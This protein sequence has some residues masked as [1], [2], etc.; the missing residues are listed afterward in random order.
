MP[1]LKIFLADLTYNTV[2]LSNEVFP[3]NVGFITSYCK[4]HFNTQVEITIFKYIDKLE[5]AIYEA[6]P[7]ILGISNY[8]WCQNIGLEMFRIFK[9][10]NP[11]GVTV[12]GG[13]NF[14]ADYQSQIA[15][16]KKH[17]IVDVYIPLEGEFGFSKVVER[18][19][20]RK[21]QT[22][23]QAIRSGDIEYCITRLNNGEL[24]YKNVGYRTQNLEEI[25]SP[26]L[27]GLLDEFFDDRLNPMIQTN[28]GCPFSC[29]F[30]VDGNDDV[31]KVNQFSVERVKQELEYIAKRVP[32]STHGLFIGDLNFGMYQR[33]LEICERIADIQQRYEYPK[34]IS[35]TTGKNSKDRI[36]KAIRKL[37]GTLKITM[38]VQSMDEQVLQNIRRDNISV[39]QMTALRPVIQEADLA[40][41]SEVILGLPGDSYDTHTR[42]IRDLIQ[43][44]TDKIL[45]YSLMMLNGS[46]L[47]IPEERQKWGIK[48]KFRILPRDFIRLRNGKTIIEID[49]T[50]V[51]SNTMSFDDYVQLRILAFILWTSYSTQ[52]QAIFKIFRENGIDVFDLFH[53]MLLNLKN[54]PSLI[55]QVIKEVKDATINELWDSPEE[56][57]EYFQDEKNYQKLLHEEMGYNVIQYFY[58][59]VVSYYSNELT[60][61][62]LKEALQMIQKKGLEE[63]IIEQFQDASNYCKGL[64]FNL[65]SKDRMCTNPEFF[66]SYNIKDWLNDNSDLKLKDFRLPEKSKVVFK[67][68]NDQTKMVND[69][70]KSYGESGHAR[71]QILK[72]LGIVL[73]SRKPQLSS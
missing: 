61:Y 24:Q 18:I 14:P 67:L 30:C 49:E 72:H 22:P 60:Q 32:K 41:I 48:T 38:S 70:F 4:S 65:F 57:I 40:S 68:T 36:I 5:N 58:A 51:G 23:I 73:I 8:I 20:D 16:L 59:K 45:I 42:T 71:S 47:N 19:L 26:Y 53:N 55:Q 35:A 28:R 27:S 64:G 31:R 7:D 37:S 25:P 63:Q 13:P 3:L 2:A 10:I 1:P 29:T 11:N 12:W 56:I 34:Y 66:F 6:T 54:A 46:E 17:Q 44:K 21:T 50:V 33:D 69:M 52:Y 62:L 39:S 9:E 15:F 43:A